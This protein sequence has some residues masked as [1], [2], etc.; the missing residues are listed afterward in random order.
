MRTP[1]PSPTASAS[2]ST[3]DVAASASSF[4]SAGYERY[5]ALLSDIVSTRTVTTD[6]DAL[7]IGIEWCRSHF[8]AALSPLKWTVRLD[9]AQNVE[10]FPPSAVLDANAPALWL[11]AHVDTVDVV[12][13]NWAASGGG[14]TADPFTARRDATHLTGRGV[15]DCKAGVAFMV[16][17]AEAIG[18]GDVAPF[19]G[20]FLVTRREESGSSLPRTSPCFA[21]GF[22][23]GR[24]FTAA[25]P[26]KTFVCC[27]ENTISLRRLE[28]SSTFSEAGSVVKMKTL[29]YN[30]AEVGVYDRERHSIVVTATAPLSTLTATLRRVLGARGPDALRDW[31]FVAIWPE[32]ATSFSTASGEEAAVPPPHRPSAF[33][34]E[35]GKE[36]DVTAVRVRRQAGG[37]SCSV[38]NVDN[39]LFDELMNIDDDESAASA[40]SRLLWSGRSDEATRVAPHLFIARESHTVVKDRPHGLLLNYRGLAPIDSVWATVAE[41][42]VSLGD[43]AKTATARTSSSSVMVSKDSETNGSGVDQRMYFDGS[44]A[45]NAIATAATALA[46][47]HQAKAKAAATAATEDDPSSL[48]ICTVCVA[49]SGPR[50]VCICEPGTKAAELCRVGPFI[51]SSSPSP[52]TGTHAPSPTSTTELSQ[53]YEPNPG[54]SDASHIWRNLPVALRGNVIVPFTCGPGHRSHRD[55]VGRFM[56][57]THGVNEGFDIRIGEAVLPFFVLLVAQFPSAQMTAAT[58]I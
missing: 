37:H 44:H 31:K 49:E 17:Y 19:N 52:S 18:R 38:R 22:T 50:P 57:K 15:N 21:G 29:P 6:E 51:P 26:H 4:V 8:A 25:A 28:S 42:R 10:A 58:A 7:T 13:E 2:S 5:L 9:A 1:E 36:D 33:D 53:R 23:S 16:W 20:G 45:S 24:L 30:S 40:S 34:A 12:V 41:I 11:S 56:R 55:V 27:L 39:V 3:S 14:T 46:A 32:T 48:F 47:H 35:C 54:R 43:A